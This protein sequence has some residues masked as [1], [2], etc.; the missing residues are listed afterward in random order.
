MERYIRKY[1]E[2]ITIPLNIGSKITYGKFL[3]KKAIVKA[4]KKNDK[5]QPVIVTETGKEISL[6]KIRIPSLMER[7]KRIYTE[8][9][10]PNDTFKIYDKKYH[11]GN[12][13]KLIKLNPHRI[14]KIQLH[15]LSKWF[16]QIKIDKDYAL[17][18]SDIDTNKP[19]I[20]LID[21]KSNMNFLIDGW[22]RAYKLFNDGKK[23]MNVYVI[24]KSNEINEITIK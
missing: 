12:A 10:L 13:D 4:F 9:V 19:G 24:D 22:H 20:F 6:L 21:K 17:K 15:P 14:I 11:I 18:L 23:F 8:D 5:G 2:D 16:D 1:N 3:N 7:Y